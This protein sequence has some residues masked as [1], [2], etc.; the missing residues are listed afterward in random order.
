MVKVKK[1]TLKK[2]AQLRAAVPKAEEPPA[3]APPGKKKVVKAKGKAA[4]P[5]AESEASK[6]TPV[7]K[8]Q[9]ADQAAEEILRA[10]AKPDSQKISAVVLPDWHLKYKDVLGSYKKFVKSSDKLQIV[11]REAGNYIIQ[12]AGDTSVPPAPESKVKDTKDWKQLLLNAWNIYHQA[13]PK[14][15]GL[16]YVILGHLVVFG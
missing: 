3:A 5:E 2:G 16:G 14:Q 11:E 1:S 7:D 15:A 9:L 13:T 12:R 4:K 6:P 10:I 8:A